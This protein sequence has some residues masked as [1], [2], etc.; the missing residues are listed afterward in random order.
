MCLYGAH[1]DPP[2]CESDAQCS[3]DARLS[4]TCGEFQCEVAQTWG[5]AHTTCTRTCEVDTDC[6]A[7]PGCVQGPV[8]TPIAKLGSLCCQKICGCRDELNEGYL[9]EI[10]ADCGSGELCQ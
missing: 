10:A 9:A 2:N 3:G 6:P 8:C 4:G 7:V 5:E 1:V